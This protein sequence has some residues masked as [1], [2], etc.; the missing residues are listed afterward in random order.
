MQVIE[1]ILRN[2]FDE[3]SL[4]YDAKKLF[5]LRKYAEILVEWNEK[6]NLTAIKE[7]KQIAIKHFLDSIMVLKHV[8]IKNEAAIVDVGTGAGFPG[9]PL[10]IFRPDL[11]LTL[12]DSLGKRIKFL[13]HLTDSLEIKVDLVCTR[14]EELGARAGFR[15][16]FDVSVSRAVAPLNILAEFCL[17][18]V[19]VGGAF[20][21]MKSGKVDVE[22]KE[23]SAAIS[24]LGGRVATV[25]RF[26]LPEENLRSI[27]VVEKI[28]K[29]DTRYPRNYAQIA[30]KPLS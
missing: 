20:L 15:E 16:K 4:E 23:G 25:A 21:A 26:S 28:A 29:T 2:Y 27:V 14:A 13:E 24:S 1:S 22:L 8:E 10:K 19:K 17:P 3:Y 30:K 12:V 7:P 6:I 9:V 18:L 11:R 5:L